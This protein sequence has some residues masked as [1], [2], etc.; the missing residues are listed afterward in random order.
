MC[1]AVTQLTQR[2]RVSLSV[3]VSSGRR[4]LSSDE[5]YSLCLRPTLINHW[6][7]KGT[8]IVFLAVPRLSQT[9]AFDFKHFAGTTAENDIP[10]I[11]GR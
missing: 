6:G 11:T 9:F 2:P 4:N 7:S 3:I 5:R 10:L 8:V 1:G